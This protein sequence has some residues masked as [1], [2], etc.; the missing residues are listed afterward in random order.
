MSEFKKIRGTQKKKLNASNPIKADSISSVYR[1]VENMSISDY[2]TATCAPGQAVE[3]RVLIDRRALSGV[4]DDYGKLQTAALAFSGKA[5]AV[6]YTPN[7]I[8]T[9]ALN[10]M[11]KAKATADGDVMSRRWL[12]LDFDPCRDT[13]TSSTADELEA[14]RLRAAAVRDYLSDK[15]WPLP[16]ENM[17]GNGYHLMYRIDLPAE[18]KLVPQVLKQLSNLFSDDSVDVDEKVGNPARIW[19]LPGTL[20][21]KGENTADRPHRVAQVRAM[22]AELTIVPREA[23]DELIGK[24]SVAKAHPSDFELA[25]FVKRHLPEAVP[26]ERSYARAFYSIPTC[27]FNSEHDRGEAFVQQ[28]PSGAVSAGCHHNSCDWQWGDL[29]R[30]FEGAKP[31]PKTSPATGGWGERTGLTDLGNAEALVR[32]HGQDIRY[33]VDRQVWLCWNGTKWQTD[34]LAG[35]AQR[36]KATVKGYYAAL[37]SLDNPAER[38]ALFKHATASE[39]AG[40]LAAMIDLARSEPE[41]TVTSDKFDA[42]QYLLT[43]KNG[44]LDLT[45]SALKPHCRE[46]YLT[47]SIALP[48]NAEATC[49]KWEAFLDEVFTGDKDTIRYLQKWAGYSLSGDT[50]EDKLVIL[51]GRGRNGKGSIIAGLVSALGDYSADTPFT[52]FIKGNNA[53]T[54]RADL[55]GLAGT[56]FVIASE[57]DEN[58]TLAEALVK[59]LTGGDLITCRELYKP[60]FTYKPRFKIW[61]ATNHIPKITTPSVA[62]KSR[63]RVIP[64]LRQFGGEGATDKCDRSIRDELERGVEAEGILA[65]AV[66]GFAM[67]QAEGLEDEPQAVIEATRDMFHEHDKLGLWLEAECILGCRQ[68]C[69]QARLWDN[70]SAWCEAAGMKPAFRSSTTFA[71]N[72]LSR[73]GISK[74]RVADGR[75]IMGIG[76]ACDYDEEVMRDRDL[77]AEE[78]AQED[79]EQTSYLFAHRNN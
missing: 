11:G 33:A 17:S 41:V 25:D 69:L 45:S 78:L 12:L 66:R 63:I 79:S 4:F 6:Y 55:A 60:F 65:W 20:T 67:W 9:E 76:L 7:P 43:C 59:Q 8:I 15:N 56:R 2:L 37:S 47:R 73:G 57:A 28:F 1:D 38:T 72:L 10:V 19:K 23:L 77:A 34:S 71:R 27:P 5:K 51:H 18:D 3:L 52:T 24:G 50:S 14:A 49:P 21:C 54:A 31:S 61:L 64:L 26:K 48:Y 58:T 46:D 36:A 32:A 53:D 35:M 44:T 22:P 40:R 16:I 70:Y 30:K 42:K 75:M 68:E 74:V 62:I 13:N 29:W 39:S